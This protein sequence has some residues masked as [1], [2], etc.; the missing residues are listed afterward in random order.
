MYKF[1]ENTILLSI[2]SAAIIIAAIIWGMFFY[3]AQKSENT[4]RAVGIASKNFSSDTAKWSITL[5]AKTEPDNLKSGYEQINLQKE[6]LMSVLKKHG[7][8]DDNFHQ[9]PI[10][11]YENYNYIT[12]DGSQQRVFEGYNLSQNFYIIS[13]QVESVEEL[14]YNPE[15][16]F[17]ENIIIKNSQLQYLYSKIDE[18][19]KE[20]ISSAAVNARERAGKMIENTGMKLGKTLSL[21][22]GVFQITEPYSTEVSSSGIYNT[23]TRKKQIRVTVHAVYQLNE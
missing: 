15:E 20:I 5:E 3:Q 22:S 17:E 14:V 2:I 8:F 19:K 23:S 12:K 13:N 6:S 10:N 18:L 7:I 16:L 11:V 1:K 9:N 4:I 21:N